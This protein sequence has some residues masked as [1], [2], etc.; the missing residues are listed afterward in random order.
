MKTADKE[1]HVLR[2]SKAAKRLFNKVNS[3][4]KKMDGALQDLE[5]KE[6]ASKKSVEVFLFF[7]LLLFNLPWVK[8]CNRILIYFYKVDK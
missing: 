6:L 8:S 1:K 7:H 5:K 3:M 2:E 4:I